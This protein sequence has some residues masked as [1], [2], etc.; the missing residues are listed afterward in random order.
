MENF[1]GQ[2]EVAEKVIGFAQSLLG[3]SRG[4]LIAGV[5]VAVLFWTVIKLLGNIE[6]SFNNIW[7]IKTSRT[8]RRKFSDYLS[9]MLV[10]PVLL[11]M[12]SSVTV[13]ITSQVTLLVEKLSF[14]GPLADGII[15]TLKFLPYAVIW[16]VFTFLYF[17]MPNTKVKVKACLVAGV[18]AGT[19]YQVLQWGYITFQVG[20]ANY[21]AIYG[22]FAALP[23]F[24]VWMQLSWLVVLF[25]A[26]VS[27]A[28]Q[29]VETYE[30]EPDSLRV[31]PSFK[32]LLALRIAHY[33]VKK[34]HQALNPPSVDEIS[35]HLEIPIRLV[36]QI[37]FELTE[38]AILS[39]VKIDDSAGVG[40]QPAHCIDDISVIGVMK[41]LDQRGIDSLPVAQS[42]DFNKLKET[43]V[44][45]QA[46]VEK[47]P[48]NLKLKDL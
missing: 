39:E 8:W 20:V 4:G 46:L 32:K 31:S 17:F 10:C 25:G 41:H 26:E 14:L 36:R 21:G 37:L 29:N 45:L 5:G 47:S 18:I 11:I 27:F 34:F 42:K 1:Q 35:E 2:Q 13:L 9:V 23:L 19:I 38:A 7:G 3:N 22:S 44:Q 16:I 40:Y 43:L 15:L 28:E 48:A 6:S 12:A 24:L 33:C 30:F